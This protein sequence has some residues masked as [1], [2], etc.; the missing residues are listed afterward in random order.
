MS[1]FFIYKEYGAKYEM[2]IQETASAKEA[3]PS[4]DLNQK[5]LEALSALL[6]SGSD[7]EYNTRRASTMKD[8]LVKVSSKP[9]ENDSHINMPSSANPEN[10]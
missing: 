4:W 1:R 9:K 2:M 8:L 5:G 6:C 7:T 3:F 10:L